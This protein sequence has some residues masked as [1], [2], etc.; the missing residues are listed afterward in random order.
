MKS[1]ESHLVASTKLKSFMDAM[2]CR[3]YFNGSVL[4]AQNG[5]ILLSQGYGMASFEHQVANTSRT[6]FRLGAITKGFTAVAILQLQE[7]GGA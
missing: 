6:K 4:V 5:Q 2:E 3:S 7:Q 1:I